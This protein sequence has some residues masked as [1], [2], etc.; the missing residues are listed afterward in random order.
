VLAAEAAGTNERRKPR[1]RAP[2]NRQTEALF[3][4]G[5]VKGILR[6]AIHPK[7]DAAAAPLTNRMKI[8]AAFA[9]LG[10]SAPHN[11]S[12][13]KPNEARCTAKSTN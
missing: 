4:Y 3:I 11:P 2:T 12:G 5:V 7:D 10:M 1:N 13:I 8:N 9:R 6:Q